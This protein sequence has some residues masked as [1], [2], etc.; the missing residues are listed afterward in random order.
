MFNFKPILRFVLWFSLSYLGLLLIALPLKE[1]YATHYRWLG[2]T[3]FEQFGK[4]GI[5]Q[6]FPHQ[7]KELK[8]KMDTKVVLFNLDQ[9][10][11]ARRSG[12]ATVRG[13]EFFTS[14]WYSALLP[15]ILLLSLILASPVSW[16]RKLL[17]T[18]AGTA[19]IYL[20]T[21]FKLRLSIAYEYHQNPWLEFS[22]GNPNWIQPA[23]RIF[24]TNIETTIIIPVFVWVL[25]TFR[26][27][28]LPVYRPKE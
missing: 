4:K 1:Q 2:K 13:G 20:F 27:S 7:E 3:C 18:L 19:L 21:L 11:A 24:V 9:V 6:F 5:V 15:S 12:Q 8:Y 23:Y 26:K 16:K 10:V 17:A 14:S 22:P 25:V 28:D